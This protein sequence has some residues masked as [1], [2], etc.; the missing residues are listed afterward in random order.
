LKALGVGVL[1][2]GKYSWQWLNIWDIALRDAK[3][4]IKKTTKTVSWLVVST[5][6]K[7]DGVRQWEG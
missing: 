5:I 3:K 7:N 4:F 6:L 2:S 1:H